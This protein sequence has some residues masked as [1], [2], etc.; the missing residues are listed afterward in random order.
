MALLIFSPANDFDIINSNKFNSFVQRYFNVSEIFNNPNSCL[1][2][3]QT[4]NL[5]NLGNFGDLEN[6]ACLDGLGNLGNSDMESKHNFNLD[7]S[8]NVKPLIIF[9]NIKQKHKD[10]QKQEYRQEHKHEHQ[11]KHLHEHINNYTIQIEGMNAFNDTQFVNI[12]KENNIKRLYYIGIGTNSMILNTVEHAFKSGYCNI[13][14]S[15]CTSISNQENSEN[16][17]NQKQSI[18]KI[19]K[20]AEIMYSYEIMNKYGCGDT[21]IFYNVM[22]RDLFNE[23]KNE[24][25]WTKMH[26]K[27]GEVPRLVA[28]QAD[29]IDGAIPIYR[30]P[31]DDLQNPT[32]MTPYVVMIQKKIEQMTGLKLNHVLIQFYRDGNDYISRH[33][34]KT[35]DICRSSFIIN[36]SLGS[37]RIMR[38]QSKTNRTTEYI[39]LINDS[40]LKMGLDTNR[41]YFHMINKEQNV[42]E[43]ISLTFR[44][45]GTFM[46]GNMLYGQGVNGIQPISYNKDDKLKLLKIFGEEN[47]DPAFD[48]D[49]NYGEGS[50]VI[51]LPDN[52]NY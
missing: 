21:S 44:E 38:L 30:H 17:N 43:R 45:I 14:V 34:D 41:E 1:D 11:H 19:R 52:N 47:K 2:I 20:M 13:V 24:V 28:C 26:H 31:T 16:C 7:L 50:N 36:Y 33:S 3:N 40:Y 10:E 48:W 12:L 35:L 8:L 6:K 9:I 27:G 32:L 46:K 37:R 29:I 49:K 23:V 22:G 42:G 18:K 5:K 39:K 51:F 4:E 25:E 15:D